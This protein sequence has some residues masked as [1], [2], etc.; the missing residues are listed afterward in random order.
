MKCNKSQQKKNYVI[1]NNLITL[2][3]DLLYS[4]QKLQMQSFT[5]LFFF[6]MKVAHIKK[7]IKRTMKTGEQKL[8]L[9]N[10]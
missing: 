6:I 5:I 3:I 8:K 4:H 1:T 7:K 2:V 10:K 9:K